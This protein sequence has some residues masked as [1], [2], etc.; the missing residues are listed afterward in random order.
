[1]RTI[2]KSLL[3]AMLVIALAESCSNGTKEAASVA[4]DFLNAYFST[5]YQGAAACCTEDLSKTLM[6]AVEDFYNME[7]DTKE[8][9][10]DISSNISTHIKSAE[11]LDKET[12]LVIYEIT[13]PETT[14]TVENK[15]T[16]KKVDDLWRV[17]EL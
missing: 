1:M 5:D 15:L 7:D 4:S 2:I 12:V 8:E 13:M 11:P 14:Q 16:I 17:S 3:A 10:K 9:V 6:E